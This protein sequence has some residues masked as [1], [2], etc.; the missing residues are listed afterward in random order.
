MNGCIFEKRQFA[1][2]SPDEAMRRRDLP[3][4][5]FYLPEEPFVFCDVRNIGL[6]VFQTGSRTRHVTSVIRDRISSHADDFF[7]VASGALFVS[8]RVAL[9]VDTLVL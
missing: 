7:Y 4:C 9:A 6:R 8:W 5:R 3:D 2:I 1:G